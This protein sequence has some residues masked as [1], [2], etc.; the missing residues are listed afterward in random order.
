[1]LRVANCKLQVVNF[2]LKSPNLKLSVIFI[3]N[4]ANYQF[5]V[6]PGNPYPA[7]LAAYSLQYSNNDTVTVAWLYTI[8]K[9]SH[10]RQ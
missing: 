10:C 1:M 8:Y 2:F 4:A 9:M 5:L 3:L 6:L 7:S